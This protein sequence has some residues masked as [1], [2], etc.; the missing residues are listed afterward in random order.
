MTAAILATLTGCSPGERVGDFVIPS[1]G[2]AYVQAPL[3]WTTPWR[4]TPRLYVSCG[5]ATAREALLGQRM[6]LFEVAADD[7]P[8][9]GPG[10]SLSVSW[11]V[12]GYNVM[13][14]GASDRSHLGFERP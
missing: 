3:S 14:P 8:Q 1:R 11:S 12:Q 6:P 9:H 10:G 4:A 13:A 7:L 2:E 5:Y